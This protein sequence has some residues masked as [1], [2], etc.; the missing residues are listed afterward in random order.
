[1]VLRASGLSAPIV[2]PSERDFHLA[3]VASDPTP[4][5]PVV[6]QAVAYAGSVGA[7]GRNYN[8]TYPRIYPAGG[9]VATTG[10]IP[11]G[12]DLFIKPKVRIWGPVL[13]PTVIFTPVGAGQNPT[14]QLKFQ[15][16]FAIPA[17]H[18]IE[19]DT[20]T[21]TVRYDG[22]P[23]QNYATALDWQNST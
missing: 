1:I 18:Y 7:G 16:T 22:D 19:I 12:G 3:W 9:N 2:G 13:G 17:N 4:Y 6:K 8:L 11:P 23:N 15:A 20:M 10:L 21:K 5:D 14:T